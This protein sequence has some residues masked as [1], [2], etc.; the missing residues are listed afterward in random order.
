VAT[1]EIVRHMETDSRLVRAALSRDGKLLAAAV[2]LGRVGAGFGERPESKIHV[3]ETETGKKQTDLTGLKWRVLQMAFS[4]DG[5]S[6]VSV[7]EGDGVW[8]WDLSEGNGRQVFEIDERY[9]RA[10]LSPDAKTVVFGSTGY[11]PGDPQ[12]DHPGKIIV[13]G[14]AAGEP[15][16]TIE[17][18]AKYPYELAVSPD[19]RIVAAHLRPKASSDKPYDGR[20]TLWHAADGREILSFPLDDGEVRSLAFSPDGKRLLSGMDRG[21]AL[22]WDVAVAYQKLGR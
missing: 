5:K 21:D 2:G 9:H 1:G 3:W 14:L 12:G 15:R 20:I 13:Y 6:L 17:T 16:L 10:V 18:P 11:V 7:G 4:L 8:R 22:V 19:G